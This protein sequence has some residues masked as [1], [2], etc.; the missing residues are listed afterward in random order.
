MYKDTAAHVIDDLHK[1]Q[2]KRNKQVTTRSFV[3]S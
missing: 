3:N 1:K 2:K